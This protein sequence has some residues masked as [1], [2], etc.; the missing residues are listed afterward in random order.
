MLSSFVSIY[1]ISTIYKI[2]GK[3]AFLRRKAALPAV[4]IITASIF[5]LLILSGFYQP[6]SNQAI[7]G[8]PESFGNDEAFLAAGATLDFN[9][10]TN[11]DNVAGFAIIDSAFLISP[12]SSLSNILPTRDG[13]MIYKVQAG[14]NLS[15]IAANFGVSL[16]TLFW[17]NP[18][19]GK[20]GFLRTGQEI[21]ILP[22]S[23]VL[24]QVK[25]NET[26][27]SIAAAYS[28]DPNRILK[29]NSKIVAGSSIIIPDAKPTK[30]STVYSAS[31]KLP[32]LA[33][34]FAIPTT[35]WNWG[36]LHY[37]NAVDIAN[38]CG[39]PIYAAAEG[40][41]V[42]AT[43]GWNQGYGNLIKIDHPNGVSTRYAHNKQNVVELGQYVVQG[44]LIA[45]MGNTGNTHGPTGCH[46]HF[47]VVGAQNP[48]SS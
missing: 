45:Y 4:F 5:N 9:I 14:D 20:R 34:F 48:F 3:L 19:L 17:A 35:G 8:G 16:N 29:L 36:R 13:L 12:G 25:S 47:E 28:V 2:L 43:S 27:A 7:L 1:G 21:V 11:P 31:L 30:S 33:G 10:A 23:G 37:N 38:A 42:K 32:R 18:N 44:D 41:V 6:F 39:T 24:H 22:V 15:N 46:V 40:L 26:L